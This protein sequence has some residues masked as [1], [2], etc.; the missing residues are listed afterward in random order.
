M[1]WTMHR[2]NEA[3]AR[4]VESAMP[5]VTARWAQRAEII[6]V[7]RC[8]VEAEAR[9]LAL[10]GER[11]EAARILSDFMSATVRDVQDDAEALFEAIG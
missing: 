9:A 2:L 10:A 5:L 3:A 11:V 7:D 6:E 4:R 1:W 8:G